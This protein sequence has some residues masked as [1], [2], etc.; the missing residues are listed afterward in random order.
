MYTERNIFHLKFGMARQ[1]V[2]MWKNYLQKTH[3]RDNSIHAR[4]Y[5]DLTGRGYSLVLELSYDSYAALEPSKCTLT[6]Q[7]DWKEF[8]QQFIPLCEFSERTLYKL[9]EAF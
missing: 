7:E 1:A 8:Y 2:G 3:S 6:K 9:E 5:T 4:L